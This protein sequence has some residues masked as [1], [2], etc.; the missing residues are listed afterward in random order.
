M[1]TETLEE[2]ATPKL[3][4]PLRVLILEHSHRDVDLMLFELKQAGLRV[5][6]TFVEDRQQFRRALQE[7]KFEVILAGFRL[8]SWTGMDAFRELRASGKDIPFLLITGTLGEEAA[9]ECIK[10]GVSDYV[11]KEHISRL[12]A[13]LKRAIQ[14]K[15]LRQEKVWAQSALAQSETQARQQFAELDLVYRSLPFALAVFDRELRFV[16]VNEEVSRA[17]GIPAAAHAGLN[18]QDVAPD[19]AGP[20]E[21]Y[22]GQVFET[23]ESVANVEVHGATRLQPAAVRHWLCSFYPLRSE[24]GTIAAATAIAID[25]TD[26]KQAEENLRLSET[27][28]RDLVDHSAYGILR[29]T[30]DGSF[31]DANP[32]LLAMLGCA[33]TEDLHTSNLERDIF[34]FP[35]QCAQL[36][37]NCRANGRVHGAESEW[38]RRDGGLVA[39]RLDLRRVSIPSHADSIEVIAED[40]TEL[41]AMERQLRQAQK[42]EAI[43]EL[44]GGVAHDF[45]NVIGAILGW[46]E[47]GYEQNKSNPQIADRFARI[48]EQAERAATLTRELL[49]FAR[50]QILQPQAVDLNTVTSSLVS[51]LDKVIAKDIELKVITSPLDPVRADPTQIE[52]V[53]MNLCLNARDAMPG[54]GRLLIETEMVELDSSYC[55]FYSSVTPGRY[56]V[57]SVSDTGVGMD[58]ATM[59]RIFEPFFTTK[60]RGK[61]T[62]MGLATVYGIIKQHGGFIH[63]YSEPGQGSLFRVY[64]PAVEVALSD[65]TPA[66]TPAP[67]LADMRGTE[68]ILIADD[69]ES[70]REMARQTLLNLGYRVLSACDGEEALRLCQNEA[71]ALAILDVVMPK[72]GGPAT[73]SKLWARFAQLPILFTSGYSRESKSM[74]PTAA[75]AHYLQKPY[76]P[77]TLG[78]LVREMLDEATA[79]KG[80][81]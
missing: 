80:I 61:G 10:A 16:R 66:K 12:P 6:C 37:A 76:S 20:M 26:R 73:A 35:E 57:L 81:G 51:F 47:L 62:G 65:G 69:H 30:F 54:G 44:A 3:T 70:I 11:L 18:L 13:A 19:F 4:E 64:L 34:R 17:D 79:S 43:G 50:R 7:G 5:A 46:A 1:K 2:I 31:L 8:P 14:E 25:I 55:R 59:E 39:V 33:S 67:S 71:P 77:I 52:Q 53:L 78:R 15:T 9:V 75:D 24:D 49:A 40:V 45:N 23:G 48:R 22:L 32:A 21:N 56:S 27:R 38:R 41:R 58:S 29:A 60:E 74:A 36:M 68:T 28:N 63:T 72:L 42:F